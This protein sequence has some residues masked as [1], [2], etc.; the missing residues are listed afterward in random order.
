[1]AIKNQEGNLAEEIPLGSEEAQPYNGFPNP[2]HVPG[3]GVPITLGWENQQRLHP[4]KRK[5]C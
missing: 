1:M 3:R 5:G 2:G 4:I